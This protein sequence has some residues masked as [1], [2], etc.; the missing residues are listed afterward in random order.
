MGRKAHYL[1]FLMGVCYYTSVLLGPTFFLG[2]TSNADQTQQNEKA[3]A[4]DKPLCY[5]CLASEQ[6][7]ALPSTCFT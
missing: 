3:A 2:A 6:Y 4:E 7:P 1:I 5:R